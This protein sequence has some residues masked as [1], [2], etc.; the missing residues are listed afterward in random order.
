[1]YFSLH[2]S[3]FKQIIFDSLFGKE[4]NAKLRLYAV[5]FVHH[6]CLWSSDKIITMMGPV[7]L[8]GMT[9]LISEDKQVWEREKTLCFWM[10][11]V[12]VQCS[13]IMTVQKT[14]NV[15]QCVSHA[16]SQNTQYDPK[17]RF[18]KAFIMTLL[19]HWQDP[20]LRRLAYTAIGKLAK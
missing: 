19:V 1:M 20:K 7:L 6:V 12:F 3:C 8:N 11:F 4:P 18:V 5:Q 10:Y 14:I 2:Y 17:T 13:K 15:L 16:E 9:K